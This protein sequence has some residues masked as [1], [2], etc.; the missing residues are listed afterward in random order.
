[1]G[2]AVGDDTPCVVAC[3]EEMLQTTVGVMLRA[4]KMQDYI[5]RY[6]R[7]AA[8][9][10]LLTVWAEEWSLDAAGVLRAMSC[11]DTLSPSQ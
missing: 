2:D 3:G 9:H 1:M 4:M 5:Q 11:I 10:Q 7:N 6:G 8:V